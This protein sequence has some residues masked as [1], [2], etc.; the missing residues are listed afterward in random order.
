MIH[1]MCENNSTRPQSSDATLKDLGESSIITELA[2]LRLMLLLILMG[3]RR[4]AMSL[5]LAY[6]G[7]A[8]YGLTWC[9][10]SI[11]VT[12]SFN[13]VGVFQDR[14]KEERCRAVSTAECREQAAGR[15]CWEGGGGGGARR[16]TG[17]GRGRRVCRQQL[18]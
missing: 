13:G 7:I 8:K 3:N 5:G 14:P 16:S 4:L 2:V 1:L 18:V 17:A 6:C 9:L 10:V 12:L 11:N 15:R